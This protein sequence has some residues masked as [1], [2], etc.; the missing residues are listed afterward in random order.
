VKRNGGVLF[1]AAEGASEI[2]IRL[3]GLV[4]T[5]FP[6]FKGKLPFAWAESCPMLTEEG[7][8]ERLV[9]IAKDA[10]DRMRSVFY[11]DLVL[12]I[13][14]TMAAAAGFQDENSSSEGQLAMNVL[15]EL[16]KRTG[17]L[18]IACDH[19]GKAV[20]TGTRGTSAKE[21]AADVI[22]A[23]LG[24][25]SE[26][27]NVT[28]LRI[29][30]RK[31][32]GGATGAETAFTCRVVDMGP[33]EDGERITTCVVEWSP[34]TISA[35]ADIAKGKAWPR[36]TT[37]FRTALV[38]TIRLHGTEQKPFPDGPT[39]RAVQLDRVHEEFNTRSPLD[40]VDRKKELNK[41]RQV[42]KRSRTEAQS[43]GLIEGREI[44]G[45]FMVW[46]INPEDRA[47]T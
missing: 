43:R 45:N 37:L 13:V 8:I 23:C 47:S 5:K 29:A 17:A 1:I 22:I 32:R 9:R 30:I 33:D 10:A 38:H 34:V 7:T 40:G 21:A 15:N 24:H 16:S 36:S 4:E 6:G 18:A 19:F 41:R 31:L 26:T 28:T 25:K 11:V 2:P 42:F 44:D 35:P 20:E 39:V 46:L 3:C 27:G 14:D 12:I